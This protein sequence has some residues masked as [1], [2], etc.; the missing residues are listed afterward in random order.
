LIKQKNRD[1][2]V[3]IVMNDFDLALE[4]SGTAVHTENAGKIRYM[5]PEVPSEKYGTKVDIWSAGV[6]LVELMTL[7]TKHGLNHMSA[8]TEQQ[9][10][11]KLRETIVS[12]SKNIYK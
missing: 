2:T 3:D 5:A 10:H 12:N 1:G 9:L 6:V 7:T 8:A 4:I 11:T